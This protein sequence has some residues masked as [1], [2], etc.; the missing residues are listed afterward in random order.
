VRELADILGRT[1]S[2]VARKLGNFGAFDP[3]LAAKG[4]S[5]LTHFGRLDMEI[6]EEFSRNWDRLV[7]EATQLLEEAATGHTATTDIFIIPGDAQTETVSTTRV[8][9]RQAFFRRAVLSSYRSTCCITG[10][11]INELLVASH[12]VPWSQDVGNRLNPQ[13]GLCLNCLHDQA[14]DR[15]L[16]SFDDELRLLVSERIRSQ[17]D[18]QTV[19]ASFS[20]FEG[21]RI[22][23]PE[24]F[25]PDCRLLARHRKA[26]G[27]QV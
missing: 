5:G 19:T 18:N 8:R 22:N 6:W 3:K 11:A 7:Q 20:V 10:I 25:A 17:Y 26:W 16:I 13:N 27:F 23:Q 9:L 2:A 24:R 15:G 12:I 14:F 4:I 1:P 21:V